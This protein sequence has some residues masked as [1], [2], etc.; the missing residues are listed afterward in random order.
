MMR[1]AEDGVSGAD[2]GIDPFNFVAGMT[3]GE[4]F[5]AGFNPGRDMVRPA[6]YGAA[7]AAAAMAAQYDTQ[8]N[9]CL[10]L[11]DGTIV[12]FVGLAHLSTANVVIA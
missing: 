4:D 6:G 7:G 2:S 9:S 8:G 3:G 5:I 12:A 11:P 1:A 10:K